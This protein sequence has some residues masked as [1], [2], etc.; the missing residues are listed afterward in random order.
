MEY[1]NPK[2]KF[3]KV[4]SLNEKLTVVFEF[5]RENWK[6]LLKFSFYLILP[7]CLI[8]AFSMN[9]MMRYAFSMGYESAAGGLGNDFFSFILNYGI[10]MILILLGTSILN[11]LVYTLMAEYERRDSRLMIITFDDF[12]ALLIRNT[13]KILRALL[14]FMGAA[15]LLGGLF[16]LLAWVSAWSLML[17]VPVLLIGTVAVMIP[18][19]L[20]MPVY[21][22]ED[23]PFFEALRKSFRY[24]FSAWGETFVVILIF[25]FLANIVSGVTMLPWYF[26]ILF[27]EIFSLTEPGEGLNATIWYQFI[28]YLLGII[29]SYGMY[30]SAILS[31]VG[32]AFQY[33]HI[34]EKKEGISVDASIRDFERL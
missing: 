2:I 24:G 14:L 20:F 21:L 29:Q 1:P 7:I 22:F 31:A 6:P 4:R 15:A 32:I 11:A 26:V 18:F 33:F 30:A 8:Q 34:R 19:S 27:G 17:T 25:G 23:I 9:S 13:G 5:L 3:Y 10:L 28:S 12:K 16:G